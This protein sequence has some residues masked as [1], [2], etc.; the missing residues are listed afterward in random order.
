MAGVQS[1]MP[2]A[3]CIPRHTALIALLPNTAW[4]VS[5]SVNTG[6]SVLFTPA[7]CAA[8]QSPALYPA[9]PFGNRLWRI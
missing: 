4:A 1:G 5:A 3:S 8:T 9:L 6:R 7:K 2:S